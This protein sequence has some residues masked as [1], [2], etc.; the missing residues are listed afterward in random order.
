VHLK[1]LTKM[2]LVLASHAKINDLAD[3]TA[4]LQTVLSNTDFL[5]E[6][7]DYTFKFLKSF[8]SKLKML[9]DHLT[10]EQKQKLVV[11]SE[12]LVA[13]PMQEVSD[14]NNEDFC[15]VLEFLLKITYRI[16]KESSN[17]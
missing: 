8:Y 1:D 15:K 14:L 5:K 7:I 10:E 17:Y 9:K 4:H 2:N 6:N 11:F 3:V 16:N 13:T 12:F